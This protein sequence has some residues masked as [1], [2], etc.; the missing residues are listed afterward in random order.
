MFTPQ[1]RDQFWAVFQET[2]TENGRLLHRR[3]GGPGCLL[4]SQPIPILDGPAVI[5]IHWYPNM[6]VAAGFSKILAESPTVQDE[7]TYLYVDD[8]SK[9][10][11]WCIEQYY[12]EIIFGMY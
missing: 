2:I 11:Y 9:Q 6:Q 4:V 12:W 8:P 3:D 1:H 10:I 5:M 7:C